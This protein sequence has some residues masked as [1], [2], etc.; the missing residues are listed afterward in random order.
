MS[1]FTTLPNDPVML[2]SFVNT[3]LR[4]S[5]PTLSDFCATYQVDEKELT[6]RLRAINYEYDPAGNAFV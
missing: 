1:N 6:E 4:D 2:L 5:C 3:A